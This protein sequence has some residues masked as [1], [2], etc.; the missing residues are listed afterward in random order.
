[1][2][3]GV[4]LSR[5][6]SVV[7]GVDGVS[8][9]GVSMMC[10]FLVLPTV[11]MLSRFPVMAGGMGMMLRR[12]PMVLGC[13]LRHTMF[14]LVTSLIFPDGIP[15]VRSASEIAATHGTPS[16]AGDRAFCYPAKD[17]RRLAANVAG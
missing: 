5:F 8:P 7:S 14:L 4:S 16:S 6:L 11:V 9:G 10:R 3:L 15:L 13:L 2:L 17:Q 12:L 1:V